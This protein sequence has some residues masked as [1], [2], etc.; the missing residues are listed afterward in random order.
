MGNCWFAVGPDEALLISGGACTDETRQ[1]LSG[2]GCACPCGP[3]TIILPL[4]IIT[5]L[6]STA[7]SKEVNNCFKISIVTLN[8]CFGNNRLK[9]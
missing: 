5:I 9:L 2:C 8:D 6:Y 3:E 1:I 7:K 4:N